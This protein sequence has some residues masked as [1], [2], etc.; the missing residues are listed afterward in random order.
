MSSAKAAL[1]SD[2]RVSLFLIGFI[3]LSYVQIDLLLIYI[4]FSFILFY[5]FNEPHFCA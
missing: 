2:T 1:E 3:S 4:F 5:L